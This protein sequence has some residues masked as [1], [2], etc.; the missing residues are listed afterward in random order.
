MVRNLK[1]RR[2]ADD[3]HYVQGE[4]DAVPS[5]SAGDA[6]T[7]DV[8]KIVRFVYYTLS[9]KRD[10]TFELWYGAWPRGY[11]VVAKG[12]INEKVITVTYRAANHHTP[13]AVIRSLEI[14]L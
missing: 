1:A 7:E 13:K 5:R 6:A 12:T 14:Q 9:I 10:N 2:Q 11:Q 8:A 3:K 4:S